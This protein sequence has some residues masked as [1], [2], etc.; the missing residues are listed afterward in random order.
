M[1]RYLLVMGLPGHM[2]SMPQAGGAQRRYIGKKMKPLADKDG[3]RLKHEGAFD[4]LFVETLQVVEEHKA[5][6]KAVKA[7]ELELLG[8]TRAKTATEASAA[9]DK[10]K[11]KYSK[12]LKQEE[13]K[14]E[15]PD[16]ID[17][18]ALKAKKGGK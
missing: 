12:K 6:L 18:G 4:D 9:F 3:N 1:K 13:K 15:A 11:A 8:K 16:V 17:V 14:P 7:G 10:L 2:V 5:V